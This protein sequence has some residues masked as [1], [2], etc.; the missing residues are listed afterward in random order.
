MFNTPRK[1]LIFLIFF[2]CLTYLHAQQNRGS[3]KSLSIE[4]G[5]SQSVVNAI[6]QDKYG[7]LWIATNDGLNKYDG[8]EFKV[9]R[10][11]DG[12]SDV[13]I[14]SLLLYNDTTLLI[15]TRNNG[16]DVFSLKSFKVVR[17]IHEKNSNLSGQ[18]INSM[19][20]DENK[21]LWVITEKGLHTIS[22]DFKVTQLL[23]TED[24]KDQSIR[25]LFV[26]NSQSVW[27]TRN[28]SGVFELK[29]RKIIKQQFDTKKTLKGFNSV[30]IDPIGNVWLGTDNGLFVKRKGSEI[31]TE[32]LLSGNPNDKLNVTHL[33][34]DSKNQIW[35]SSYYAGLI[36]FNP[37][38]NSYTWFAKGYVKIN[39]ISLTNVNCSFEDKSGL[40]WFGTNGH[41]LEYF[42]PYNTKFTT[43]NNDPNASIQISGRSIRKM[44]R[45]VGTTDQ[46]WIGSYSGLDLFSLKTGL[47]KNF[48]SFEYGKKGLT[49]NAVYD[50]WQNPKDQKLFI[51]T[52]GEGLL[53]YDKAS[54][55]FRSPNITSIRPNNTFKIYQSS[56]QRIWL[57]T[58]FGLFEYNDKSF[59]IISKYQPYLASDHLNVY[60]IDEYKNGLILSSNKGLYL[61]YSTDNQILPIPLLLSE[62]NEPSVSSVLIDQS[63]LWVCTKGSGLI[64]GELVD[65]KGKITFK[66]LHVFDTENGLPNDVVYN[67]I[68]SKDNNIWVSSNNGLIRIN[69]IDN[70]VALYNYYDG[71]Q[72]NE[73]NNNSSFQDENGIIYFG[74]INGFSYF[75]PNKLKNNNTL[76]TISFTDLK[77]FNN[78]LTYLGNLNECEMVEIP[79]SDN[80]LTI[81]FFAS[82]YL[83][84][85][86]INYAYKLYGFNN[87]FIQLGNKNSITFTNL[88]PG[89]Y[90][91]KVIATN[92]DGIWN[93]K[94]GSIKIKIIPPFWLTTWFIIYI[95]AFIGL[96]GYLIYYLRTR[97]MKA[98]TEKLEREVKKRTLELEDKNKELAEAKIFA[99]KNANTKSEFLAT[100]SH[101]IRTPMNGM[102]GMVSMLENTS[103]NE[104]QRNYVEI[105]KYSSDNLIQVINDIL[106]YSK[107]D[108]GKLELFY[109]KTN[110][111]KLIDSCLELFV[112]KATEKNI[113][114]VSFIDKDIPEYVN[115]DQTRL[116]QVLFNLLNNAVKFTPR[117]HISLQ[118][119]LVRPVQDQIQLQFQVSDTGIGI[120]NEKQK[121][122]FELFTQ[123]DSSISRKFGGTGLGL[124]ICK[125]LIE[126]MGG[127]IKVTS[128]VGEGSNFTFTIDTH[129]AAISLKDVSRTSYNH[130]VL[131][132]FNNLMVSKSCVDYLDH[133]NIRVIKLPS[134]NE[135]SNYLKSYN[136]DILITDYL[137][138]V[139]ETKTFSNN[140]IKTVLFAPKKIDDVL[141]DLVFP[142]PISKAKIHKLLESTIINNN[143]LTQKEFIPEPEKPLAEKFPLRI[144]VAEDHLINQ[145]IITKMFQN[146]GYEVK[147]ANNGKEAFWEVGRRPYDIIFMDIHMPEMDG[148]EATKNIRAVMGER[149][150]VIIA[151]TASVVAHEIAIYKEAG[152]ADVLAK[153]I[154]LD[155]IKACLMKWSDSIK[156]K[157]L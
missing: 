135:L 129:S 82:D 133:F 4:D 1:Y 20:L 156:Q 10:K 64:K 79:Y 109:E 87:Q 11:K 57:G 101:E 152:M 21:L 31:F 120:E 48:N 106:D 27:F 80:V 94:G 155:E 71:L 16:I 35:I 112:I 26:K 95:I 92:S 148:V 125:N 124:T 118:V 138:M 107:I 98:L 25:T 58:N 65:D 67:A 121:R 117:G 18:L 13:S 113:E 3:F 145:K 147:I 56:D 102:V 88:D 43:I 123:A 17:R 115:I 100:M 105:I 91:L 131:V 40:I 84:T 157:A 134:V 38:Q 132:Y 99:E 37:L 149:A 75:D 9:Y 140:Q 110:L 41:G 7:F 141:I 52:E 103:L 49:T 74:G 68:K 97:S 53:Y 85:K 14:L 126:L 22:N 59:S 47:I 111:N 62:Y 90:I 89:E 70:T 60:D 146:M 8:Y 86:R 36:K 73:F 122:I 2:N 50:I 150:P 32:Q 151:V 127:D 15:G 6:V 83:A 154:N 66:K 136:I 116:K 23:K 28:H 12:L 76:P 42:S 54:D 5:L 128:K 81:S 114:L 96:I 104:E 119:K 142:K 153:P 130:S 33:M 51:G 69:S 39:D 19:K 144:L 93:N 46:L 139:G 29:N 34:L 24:S 137:P 63:T 45:V 30:T 108:S 55:V 78:S 72:G 77:V 61:Y 44:T 143:Q